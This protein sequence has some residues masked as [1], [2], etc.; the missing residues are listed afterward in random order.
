MQA[1]KTFRRLKGIVRL[2]ILTQ[3]YSTKRQATTTLTHLHSWGKIQSEIRARRLSMVTEG[4]LRQKKLENQIK[5]EAKLHD[6]EVRISAPHVGPWGMNLSI[7]I[8]NCLWTPWH[9][10]P[11]EGYEVMSG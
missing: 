7:K 5:L 8:P 1:R 3:G 4:R 11:L 10:L 9:L 2:Q 6:L